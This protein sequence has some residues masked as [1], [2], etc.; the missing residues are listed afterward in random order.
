MNRDTEPIL[1]YW[2]QSARSMRV[3][4]IRR[5]EGRERLQINLENAVYY[6]LLWSGRPDGLSAKGFGTYLHLYKEEARSLRLKGEKKMLTSQDQRH[7]EEELL[8]Y[9]PRALAFLKLG[10]YAACAQDLHHCMELVRFSFKYGKGN[11]AAESAVEMMPTLHMTYYFALCALSLE[12]SQSQRALY[13]LDRGVQCIAADYLHISHRS[14]SGYSEEA[15][16]LYSFK[17]II[18]RESRRLSKQRRGTA[19]VENTRKRSPHVPICQLLSQ[20]RRPEVES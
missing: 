11:T 6:R 8:S 13:Y 16:R 17:E 2:L 12:M 3:R 18:L 4:R 15:L 5:I 7:L 9:F 1:Y 10:E 14:A 20:Q 19:M